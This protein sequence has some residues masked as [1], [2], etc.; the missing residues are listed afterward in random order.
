MVCLEGSSF[1]VSRL[2]ASRGYMA[3]LF[4]GQGIDENLPLYRSRKFDVFDCVD[5]WEIVRMLVG[6]LLYLDRC[7]Q[8]KIP[9]DYQYVPLGPDSS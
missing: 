2:E 7:E 8:W 4:E 3:S 9:G 1:Y 6:V 5:R